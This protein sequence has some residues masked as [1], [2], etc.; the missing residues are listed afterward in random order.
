MVRMHI[1]ALGLSGLGPLESAGA[2]SFATERR[3]ETV[4]AAAADRSFIPTEL[5]APVLAASGTRVPWVRTWL[6]REDMVRALARGHLL[7]FG[8]Q[9][10]DQ[11]LAGVVGLCGFENAHGEALYNFNFGNV[12]ARGTAS[13]HAGEGSEIEPSMRAFATADE[14]AADLWNVLRTHHGRALQ[15]FDE[16]DYPKGVRELAR[17]GYFKAD[18]ERY[19]KAVPQLADLALRSTIPGLRLSASKQ[20][21]ALTDVAPSPR[22]V[23]LQLPSND[24]PLP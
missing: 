14:G 5:S 11:R 21:Q 10:T 18:A 2:S 4:S 8:V 23:A 20:H 3:G 1:L 13:L 16:T 24:R 9:A 6:S 12:S 15:A 17:Y 19:A 7:A 22:Y